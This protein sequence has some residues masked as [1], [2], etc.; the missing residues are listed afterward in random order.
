MLEVNIKDFISDPFLTVWPDSPDAGDKDCIC[1]L[2]LRMIDDA[3]V[4]IRIP[5]VRFY[6][7]GIRKPAEMRFHILC[8][9]LADAMMRDEIKVLWV[10]PRIMG[11]SENKRSKR[12]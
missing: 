12:V 11:K 10:N 9:R 8:F 3:Q 4:P 2:C 5:A 1:S 6:A 7:G